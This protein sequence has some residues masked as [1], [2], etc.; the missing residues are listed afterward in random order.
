MMVPT[1][2]W[3]KVC[4]SSEENIFWGQ[5]PHLQ[6]LQLLQNS[7]IVVTGL[8]IYT[9]YF[10]CGTIVI[11]LVLGVWKEVRDMCF[12]AKVYVNTWDFVNHSG[13]V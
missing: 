1:L 6:L 13:V 7:Y 8:S 10:Q 11:G 5:W 9:T 4:G 12:G 2:D 3:V